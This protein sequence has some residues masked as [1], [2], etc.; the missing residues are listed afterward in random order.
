[1][2]D[3]DPR[4][5]I[6]LELMLRLAQPHE[7][8]PPGPENHDELNTIIAGLRMLAEGFSTEPSLQGSM[9]AERADAL[10]AYEY[11]PALLCS[12]DTDGSVLHCNQTF[13]DALGLPREEVVGHLLPELYTSI[14]YEFAQAC[15]RSL[16]RDEPL[17]ARDH[18]LTRNGKSPLIAQL[19]GHRVSTRPG[20]PGRMRLA[21]RDVTAERALELQ[22]AQSQK[23]EAIGQLA[24][25]V[26]HDFNNLLTV[27]Q[28]TVDVL[29]D[30]VK[31]PQGIEDL[32]ELTFAAKRG[33]ELANQLLSFARRKPAQHITIDLAE[34]L[35]RIIRLLSRTLGS[36]VVIDL[37]LD[38]PLWPMRGDPARLENALIN[39]AIN[40]RDALPGGGRI[41][42]R[43]CNVT[44][45][46]EQARVI[47]QAKP[48]AYVLLTIEDSGT[49]MSPEVQRRAFEPFFTTKEAG[50][51]T[52]LGLS[53]VQGVVEQLGGAI[54]LSSTPGAGT[55][56][57]L[58]FPRA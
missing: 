11:A 27:I 18:Q 53:L 45:D 17:P 40:A 13:L 31:S 51:G 39:L 36:A 56:F 1:M 16:S 10:A 2:A 12:V 58:Y 20:E 49:G 23:L 28:S 3:H 29:R 55:Q 35:Q 34:L 38:E 52:G 37:L 4:L 41:S 43:A 6:A 54:S 48:G 9:S 30:E 42:I 19:S 8:R 32:N 22:L 24:G 33:G 25:G 57:S 44:L 15:L 26:A 14:E 47:P 5:D 21:Y 50:K 46:D 7:M